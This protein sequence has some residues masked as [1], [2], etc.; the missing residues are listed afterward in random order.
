[1]EKKADDKMRRVKRRQGTIKSLINN[2]MVSIKHVGCN[3]FPT[4]H[5]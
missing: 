4:P 1:M 3:M 2:H 5:Q